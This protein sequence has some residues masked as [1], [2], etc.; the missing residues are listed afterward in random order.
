MAV[1]FIASTTWW[2]LF[3]G[4]AVLAL[5]L[6]IRE[7]LRL[8]L[9][10]TRYFVLTAALGTLAAVGWFGLLVV[11]VFVAGVLSAAVAFLV[12]FVVAAVVASAFRPRDPATQWR[13]S[14]ASGQIA[15]A[16]AANRPDVREA[17]A[18]LGKTV[19]DIDALRTRLQALGV[20]GVTLE[21]ALANTDLLRWY[22]G[23]ENPSTRDVAITLGAWAQ[24]G[25]R[26]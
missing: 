3:I 9:H 15:L 19:E 12:T 26:P 2:L 1:S 25:R 13:E 14:V 23:L 11:M 18:A 6:G 5:L 20:T 22:F 7:R 4:A 10:G 24:R 21:R 16:R 8:R 17:L